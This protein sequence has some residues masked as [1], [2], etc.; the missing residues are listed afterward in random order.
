MLYHSRGWR[1]A[2]SAH[3]SPSIPTPLRPSGLCHPFIT[4]SSLLPFAPD[5]VHG[6]FGRVHQRPPLGVG[7]RIGDEDVHASTAEGRARG[8]EQR[9]A[10]RGDAHVTHLYQQCRAHQNFPRRQK[11]CAPPAQVSSARLHVHKRAPCR[12]AA[13]RIPSPLTT[14]PAPHRHWPGLGRKR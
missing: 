1:C 13:P 11:A 4:P 6:G 2:R 8:G 3:A 14:P 12:G 7:R 10:L 5:L 9:C